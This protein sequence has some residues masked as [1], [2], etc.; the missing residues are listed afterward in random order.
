MSEGMEKLMSEGKL[1]LGGCGMDGAE[2]KDLL[3]T[4]CDKPFKYHK[5]KK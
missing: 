2:G 3:C 5:P 1:V 4:E